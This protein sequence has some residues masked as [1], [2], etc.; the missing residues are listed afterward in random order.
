MEDPK[1]KVYKTS[2]NWAL[3]VY[4]FTPCL[5]GLFLY[6]LFMILTQETVTGT[7]LWILTLGAVAM[8]G[9]L[10][11]GIINTYRGRII[12]KEDRIVAI[13]AFSTTE[14]RL[15][16]IK[17][18]TQDQYNINIKPKLESISPIKVSQYYENS[19]EISA[20]LNHQF[21]NLEEQQE[22][23]EAQSILKN[24]KFGETRIARAQALKAAEKTSKIINSLGGLAALWAFFFPQPY[25]FVLL[26]CIVMPLIAIV[27]LQY[28]D[29]LIKI[30]QK[31]GSAYPSV[32]HAIMYP[33]LVLLVRAIFD[34]NISDY[35]KVGYWC[36][37]LTILIS[38]WIYA[39]NQFVHDNNN[40]DYKT[41]LIIMLFFFAY[42]FGTV[43]H[44]NC[45]YD[46]SKPEL[47]QVT[48]ISKSNPSDNYYLKLTPWG[49]QQEPI[50]T[51]V[52]Q[53][54]YNNTKVNDQIPLESYEGQLGIPWFELV[55]Q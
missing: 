55:N 12:I 44:I 43:I 40:K 4:L 10:L 27:A 2:S 45:S 32:V 26:L 38:F 13:N 35:D 24:T 48:V 41:I 7:M 14:L 21:P 20:W 9:V 23:K 53:E 15:D 54:R 33:P 17:G 36:F 50:K 29:G 39:V 34:F 1:H 22:R 16:E 51:E 31:N 8:I 30:D 3:T 42:S 46:N 19:W 49:S 28:S 25:K 6:V 5:I 47:H 37:G 18:Y 52:S 11:A